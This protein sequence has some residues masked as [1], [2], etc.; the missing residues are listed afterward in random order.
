[1]DRTEI[2]AT[3]G[4]AKDRWDHADA[5]HNP[6]VL[7]LIRAAEAMHA[8]LYGDPDANTPQ[9]Q[10]ETRD[11][12][13]RIALLCGV[14]TVMMDPRLRDAPR[15][16]FVRAIALALT[17]TLIHTGAIR[18]TPPDEMPDS[19]PLGLPEYLRPDIDDLIGGNRA[20]RDALFPNGLP[21]AEPTTRGAVG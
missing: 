14:D 20:V 1:M 21:A 16:V 12:L 19:F 5:P 13:T 8:K 3:I 2:E 4:G 17:G 9:T 15:A 10:V 11:Q 18:A 7:A 6:D